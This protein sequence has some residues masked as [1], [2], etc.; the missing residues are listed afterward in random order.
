MFLSTYEI[1]IKFVHTRVCYT[2]KISRKSKTGKMEFSEFQFNGQN[3]A[4]CKTQD[5][6]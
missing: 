3:F 5:F 4:E 6:L 1:Y 2:H